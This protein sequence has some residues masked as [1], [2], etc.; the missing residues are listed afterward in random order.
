MPKSD[1]SQSAT[2]AYPQ[3]TTCCHLSQPSQQLS[4]NHRVRETVLS[5]SRAATSQLSQP[6][7]GSH[8]PLRGIKAPRCWVS[9]CDLR[10]SWGV[11]IVGSSSCLCGS[12]G[13]EGFK[14][15]F[16][17]W[18]SMPRGAFW[19]QPKCCRDC[20]AGC[21]LWMRT[22]SSRSPSAGEGLGELCQLKAPPRIFEIVSLVSWAC[23]NS[24][25][26]GPG[27]SHLPLVCRR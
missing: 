7:R 15:A 2:C 24:C 16:H 12:G 17:V 18:C 4:T 1:Q 10:L 5:Q 22:R 9:R 23:A 26:L 27:G 3:P 25:L 8:T 20:S 21:C 19:V 6:I 11:V 14:V 13:C